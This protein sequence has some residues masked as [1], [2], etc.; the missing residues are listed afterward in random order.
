MATTYTWSVSDME[1]DPESGVVSS[2]NWHIDA[3]DGTY[4]LGTGGLVVL[5]APA[6]GD[7]VVPYDTLT[8]ALVCSWVCDKLGTE[9]CDAIKAELQARLD[10]LHQ[11]SS[12][13]G[14]PW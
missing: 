10:E 2:V 3:E 5:D 4:G 13:W 7:S 12:L 6:E 14:K 11:P 9:Q 8:E 1:R